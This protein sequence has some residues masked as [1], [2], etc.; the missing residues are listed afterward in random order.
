MRRVATALVLCA[1]IGIGAVAI[2]DSVRGDGDGAPVA[3]TGADGAAETGVMPATLRVAGSIAVD[4][5]A[6]IAVA[7]GSV[8]VTSAAAGTVVRID[9][10][11]NAVVATIELGD[12]RPSYVVAGRGRVW[13]VDERRGEAVRIDP[14]TNTVGGRIPIGESPLGLAFS[15]GDAWVPNLAGSSVS[16]IDPRDGEL[17]SGVSVAR[18]TRLAAGTAS[19]WAVSPGE[20]TVTR[21]D[22]ASNLVLA[23]ITFED[24]P[25][26]I[27][28][29]S[30]AVWV[31]HPAARSI[32]RID[33]ATN[34]VAATI[35]LRQSAEPLFLAYGGG[36][37]WVLS[38]TNIL[39]IDPRTN[40]VAATAPLELARHPGPEPLVLGGLAV[41]EGGAWVAD[42]YASKIVRVEG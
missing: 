25:D 14:A 24:A 26:D 18:P 29:G 39:R 38:L 23:T 40:R 4:R 32:S 30:G 2:V 8:W 37:L 11:R 41:G 5:P 27:A 3:T 42:T 36:G 31:S 21:I 13:V 6:G 17:R 28:V 10:S 35:R 34:K 7:E 16:R 22:T 15:G 20:R 12:F 19:V 1:L 33:P 9:P